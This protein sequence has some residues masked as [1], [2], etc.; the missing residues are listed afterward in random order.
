L[1]HFHSFAVNHRRWSP[2][3]VE[4]KHNPRFEESMQRISR[5]LLHDC[6]SPTKL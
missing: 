3:L 1:R 5:F 4:Q 6:W 2:A